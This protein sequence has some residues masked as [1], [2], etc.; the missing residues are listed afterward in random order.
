M[1]IPTVQYPAYI[2]TRLIAGNE[3]LKLSKQCSTESSTTITLT[4]IKWGKLKIKRK[5]N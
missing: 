4:P 2:A 3:N 5:I 1:K